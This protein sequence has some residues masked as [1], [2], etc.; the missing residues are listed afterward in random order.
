[1]KLLFCG[2]IMPGGVLPYQN[3]YVQEDVLSFLKSFDLRIGTLECAIGNDMQFDES[4][5]NAEMNIVY[6]R[7]E[8]FFRV[9]ELGIDIV[10]LAN[11]HIFD[12]G[13]EGLKNTIECLYRNNIRYVGAGMNLEE[14]SSP[15]II[16]REGISIAF[17]ACCFTGMK[18]VWV[19][20]ATPMS[21]GI[22]QTDIETACKKIE[23]AKKLYDCVIVLPHWGIELVFF[24]KEEYYSYAQKMI[25]AGADSVL[26]SH[27]HMI[28]PYWKYKGKTVC[29]SLGN[30]LF[31][32][33]CM[34]VP[35]P[36]FYP[37]DVEQY[38]SLERRWFYPKNFTHPVVS[39]WMG[40][41]RIGSMISMKIDKKQIVVRHR[42][43]MLTKDNVLDLYT[44]FNSKI[45]YARMR[46]WWFLY[47][48]FG[49]RF[50]IRMLRSRYNI[51]SKMLNKLSAF[52]ISV[53]L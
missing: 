9:K 26:G 14:A 44:G 37:N 19:T 53:E 20:A 8:D 7:N 47:S 16:E 33:F 1:M 42:L 27:T 23:E 35:K 41:C 29:Y 10:S 38:R 18:P 45:V 32:D 3:K 52:N 34:Q 12:L 31:P 30:F 21:A 11:N 36:Q 28:G 13:E 25:D 48:N 51:V 39:V 46:V 40:R 43:S 4:K 50:I 17:F 49:C 22:W 15:L 24:P 2:D 5:M 6:A